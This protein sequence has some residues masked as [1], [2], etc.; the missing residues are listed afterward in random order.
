MKKVGGK[1]NYGWGS[2]AGYA[3]A[4][5]LKNYYQDSPA[6]C[7][8]HIDRWKVFDSFL[9]N[10]EIRDTQ[11]VSRETI[12]DFAELLQE[13]IINGEK[14]ISYTSNILSTTNVVLR[15]LREDNSMFLSPTLYCGKRDR[16]RTEPPKGLNRSDVTSAATELNKQG[17][18]RQALIPE[19][20]R[21][22]GLRKKEACLLNNQQALT[23]AEQLQTITVTMGTKGGRGRNIPRIISVDKFGLDLL[24]RA[25]FAQGDWRC[26]VPQGL[27]LYKFMASVNDCWTSVRDTY[28]LSTIKDLRSC[29]ACDLYQSI[30]HCP[31]PVLANGLLLAES[32]KHVEALSTIATALGHGR[33]QVVYAYVGRG[34]K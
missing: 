34:K 30:T 1:A 20:A 21:E 7:H 15:L 4:N 2:K 24:R 22:F 10:C 9:R 25:A 13:D 17:N 3:G 8:S 26:L 5:V 14:S 23:E 32:D 27:P 33:K 16:S 12:I 18:T 6:T 19:L 28:D 11:R 31:P 29:Y